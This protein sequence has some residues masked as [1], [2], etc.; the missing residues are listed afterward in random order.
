MTRK[1]IILNTHA[2]LNRVIIQMQTDCA[3]LTDEKDMRLF[4]YVQKILMSAIDLLE[5]GLK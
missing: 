5:L 3:D 2:A 1:E 4:K